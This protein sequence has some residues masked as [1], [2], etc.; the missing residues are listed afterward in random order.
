MGIRR[1]K[2][3]I[4][5]SVEHMSTNL[6]ISTCEICSKCP[7]R[8]Y[9]DKDDK[10]IFG[11]G[12]I[13]TDTIMILPSY[14]VKAGIEYPTILKIMQDTYKNITGKELLEDCYV[15]RTIKCFNKT[16]FNLE[17][18]AI[19]SCFINLLYEVHRIKPK[20]V[21]ILDRRIYDFGLYDCNKG[22]FTVKTVIS[23]GV[24][25][26]DNQNLKDIFMEQLTEA[27]NDS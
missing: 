19:K 5:L 4:K 9:A 16:D 8:I 25:Y 23:P 21:I 3:D 2:K 10:I 1:K 20:K 14:D 18:I 7:C 26:Y 24:M 11:V 6:F 22:K 12:N 27:I 13:Y 17:I 15:T